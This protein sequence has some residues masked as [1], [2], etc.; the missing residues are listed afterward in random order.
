ME[1]DFQ[2]HTHAHAQAHAHTQAHTP[3]HK[4][5]HAPPNSRKTS[6]G[7]KIECELIGK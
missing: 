4:R 5:A 7:G 1:A 6:A 3:A 2:E